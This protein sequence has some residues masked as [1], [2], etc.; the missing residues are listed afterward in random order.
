METPAAS[1]ARTTAVEADGRIYV[2]AYFGQAPEGCPIQSTTSSRTLIISNI[3]ADGGTTYASG[4][5]VSLFD[6]DGTITNEPLVRFT[7]TSATAVDVRPRN[8]VSFSLDATLDGG[9]VSGR[10][11][12]IHCPILDG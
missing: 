5:R 2:E 3:N 4:L 12:A 8:E 1:I 9:V 10:F 6:F 11:T 7:E